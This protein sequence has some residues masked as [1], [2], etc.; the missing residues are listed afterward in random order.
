MYADDTTITNSHKS[1]ARRSP[2][3]NLDLNNLQNKVLPNQLSL[4]VVKTEYMYFASDYN[5][6]NL[7]VF[8]IDPHENW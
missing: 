2:G 5:L 8:E 4:N 7:G 1:K 3:S 6:S